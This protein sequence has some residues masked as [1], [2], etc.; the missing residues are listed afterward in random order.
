[1]SW[2]PEAVRDS[3]DPAVQ[4][5]ALIVVSVMLTRL[6]RHVLAAVGLGS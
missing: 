2:L 6:F 5:A 4:L 3:V 1:M